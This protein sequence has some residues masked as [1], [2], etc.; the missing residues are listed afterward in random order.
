MRNIPTCSTPFK[1][2][3]HCQAVSDIITQLWKHPQPYSFSHFCSF[4]PG[5]ESLRRSRPCQIWSPSST[6]WAY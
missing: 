2:N 4:F 5:K 1:F 3:Q 6:W